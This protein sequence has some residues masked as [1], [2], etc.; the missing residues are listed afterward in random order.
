MSDIQEY[1][2]QILG[3]FFTAFPFVVMVA[4]G[5]FLPVFLLMTYNKFRVGMWVI[6]GIYLLEALTQHDVG[7]L[8]LGIDLTATD[9]VFVV[10]GLVAGLRLLIAKDFPLRHRAWLLF[11][12]VIL[13]NLVLGILSY[14]PTAGVQ[15]RP[16]YYFMM[17]GLYGMSFPID[18]RC[19]RQMLNALVI[20]AIVLMALTIYRWAVYYTPI[21]SLMP[22]GGT[23]NTDGPIRVIAS[24]DALI[25]SEVL[26]GAIFFTSVGRG[27]KLARLL[28]PLLFI[29]VL[30]LQHRSIWLAT[31]VG[32][33]S[34][35]AFAGKNNISATRQLVL[36]AFVLSLTSLPMIFSEQVSDVGAQIG[37]SAA[38]LAHGADTT[39]ER[40]NNWKATISK[41]YGGGVKSIIIGQGFGGDSSREVED[42]KGK[43]RKITYFAHNMYVQTLYNGGLVGLLAFLSAVVYIIRGLYKLTQTYTKTTE[44]QIL[45]VLM[46]MQVAYYVP[47]GTD[48]LQSLI[49]G[50]ALSFVAS[51]LVKRNEIEPKTQGVQSV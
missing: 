14:G 40:L 49:F 39:A 21:Q 9:F 12:L 29:Q 37:S 48:F 20:T 46:V 43:E 26:V 17:A 6:V 30:V 41:W 13:V 36:L 15:A 50:V 28:T 25:L 44:A 27:L 18:E 38:R 7:G 35:F 42:S 11:S 8:R 10:I 51:N 33:V 16:Y 47:Y 31:I 1:F 32:V 5:L 45:L 4:L 22:V 2:Y 23:Y 19:V 3:Y 34:S 24:N